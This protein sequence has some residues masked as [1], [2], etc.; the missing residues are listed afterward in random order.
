[1][2]VEQIAAICHEANLVICVANGD[3]SQKHWDEA[4]QWQKESAVKGVLFR[5][6]NPLAPV[7]AQHEAWSA[8]KLAEGW[9]YGPEKNAELKTHPCLV[10]YNELPEFQQLKDKTFVVIVEAFKYSA[11]ALDRELTEGEKAV[12]LSFN[13]SKMPEVDAIKQVYAKA[14]DLADQ[15]RA[16]ATSGGK[17]RYFSTSITYAEIAQMEAVKALTWQY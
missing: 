8:D 2:T 1:M 13:P 10:P 15:A 4:E 3:N 16:N 12:G 5:L 11:G 14:I 7:S 6:N 9:V 17:K